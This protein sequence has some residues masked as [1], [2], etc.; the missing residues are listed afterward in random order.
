M[1]IMRVVDELVV[2][3]RV[4]GLYSASLRVLA[5]A[6]GNFAV[7]V[8]PVGA[9]PGNWVFTISGSAARYALDERATTTDLTIGGIIDHWDEGGRETESKGNKGGEGDAEAGP[10]RRH[11]A[12]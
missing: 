12:A 1:E 8:D 5:D 3:R 9:H 10:E 2:T 4:P 11:K 7:A 6:K